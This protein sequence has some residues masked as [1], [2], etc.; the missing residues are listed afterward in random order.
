MIEDSPSETVQVAKGFY[1]AKYLS[2]ASSDSSG[3][4]GRK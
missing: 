3:F 4:F 2:K 1:A